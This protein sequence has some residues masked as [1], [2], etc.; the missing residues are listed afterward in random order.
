MIASIQRTIAYLWLV[1]LAFAGFWAAAGAAV[2]ATISAA[3]LLSG[4][5]LALAV[6]F[7]WMH[8]ANRGD[9]APRATAKQLL[10]AWWGECRHAPTV[11]LWRQPFQAAR[12]P[13]R[14]DASDPSAKHRTGVVLIHGFFCNRGL[15]NLWLERLALQ[16]TPVMA[17][18]LEPPFGSIDDYRDT[19]EAALSAMERSTGLPPVVVAHS[20]GGLALRRWWADQPANA[21]RV[22]HAITIGTPH[23]GTRLAVWALSRNGRQMRQDSPWLQALQ[24]REPADRASR[25]T[26]FYSHTDNIVFPAS[27][28]TMPGADNRHLPA[29]AHVAMVDHPAPWDE[30]QRLLRI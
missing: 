13:D 9:T 12:W 5:A 10:Q 17:L 1:G 4:H 15:W 18:T 14:L 29:T 26:C 21:L 24:Q 2:V 22:R 27:T 20:M 19:V 16:G 23:R 8:G 11:F 6:E 7:L 28:A 25:M 30:L 3:L